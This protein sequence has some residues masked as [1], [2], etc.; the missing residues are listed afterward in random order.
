MLIDPKEF[1]LSGLPQ[2]LHPTRTAA[3][4]RV[5]VAGYDLVFRGKDRSG[6]Q[7]GNGR[8]KHRSARQPRIEIGHGG[9]PRSGI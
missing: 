1:A 8:N 2:V 5:Q 3:A 9:P 6:L 7:Q 4:I